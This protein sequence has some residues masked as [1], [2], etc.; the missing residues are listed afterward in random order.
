MNIYSVAA[1]PQNRRDLWA[2]LGG[3]LLI[4]IFYG[5]VSLRYVL[6]ASMFVVMVA[7]FYALRRYGLRSFHPATGFW[8]LAALCAPVTI[9]AILG[10]N[11][12]HQDLALYLPWA[13]A[14][15]TLGVLSRA[16]VPELWV[17]RGIAAGALLTAATMVVMVFLVPAN[18]FLIQG[19]MPA[20]WLGPLDRAGV[21]PRP[22]L[23]A[24]ILSPEDAFYAQ[25]NLARNALGR[26]NYIAV[27]LVFAIT[28]ALFLRKWVVA[29][30]VGIALVL[31]QSRTGV[32][33]AAVGAPL[34]LFAHTKNFKVSWLLSAGGIAVFVAALIL[35][36]QYD[37]LP[38]S[39]TARLGLVQQS[40]G[41]IADHWLLGAPRSAIMAEH[42]LGL[43]WSPH[44]S[45][46]SLLLNFG[47]LGVALYAGYVSLALR[48][49]SL[50]GK[51][52][53]LWAGVFYAFLLLFAW[54]LVEIIVMTPA[55]EILL[56]SLFAMAHVQRAGAAQ[57]VP[58]EAWSAPN[59]S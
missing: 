59:R 46:A 36:T 23:L 5:D 47:V 51:S 43:L 39:V 44:N 27:F 29:T 38:T 16:E 17:W 55:F 4:A 31:T 20:E 40:F 57:S 52:S 8:L 11:P 50:L 10:T 12:T 19:Q 56:A 33:A 45:V 35:V 34:M 14:S 2:P 28:V 22:N 25:K 7:G 13:Y 37:H 49:F 3:G 32:A 15:L 26:S 58:A 18:I 1:A 30:I 54:S 6:P 53:S 24:A 42:D 48:E 41:P 21:A 9:Q